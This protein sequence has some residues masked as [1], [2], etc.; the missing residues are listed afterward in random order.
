MNYS[1]IYDSIIE[2]RNSLKEERKSLKKQKL[3]YF[4]RHHIIPKCMGG[5]NVDSNLILLTAKEHYICHHLLYLIY[6][7][8]KLA[9]A[10][11]RLSRSFG[12]GKNGSYRISARTYQ[13]LKELHVFFN[14]REYSAEHRAKISAANR[15]RKRSDEFKEKV[16]KAN[17][18]KIVSKETREKMRISSLGKFHTVE[19]KEKISEAGRNRQM[20]EETKKKLSEKIKGRKNKPFSLET[21]Q[22]MSKTHTGVK[23]KPHSEETIQKMRDARQRIREQKIEKSDS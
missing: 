21:R 7:D 9:L 6:R 4:E 23:R 8:Q 3:Q 12:K 18:G 22:K 14:K 16:S 15:G 10:W 11:I 20:S 13:E 17:K 5:T 19:T 2:S 1:R